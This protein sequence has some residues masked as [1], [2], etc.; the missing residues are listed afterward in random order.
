MSFR[1]THAS[2]LLLWGGLVAELIASACVHQVL[3]FPSS[4]V[5]ASTD[6]SSA[7][8]NG[9]GAAPVFSQE[10]V[11]NLVRL[12]DE[13]TPLVVRGLYIHPAAR[14]AVEQ[15]MSSEE[16]AE[17]VIQN[18]LPRIASVSYATD[19]AL[20]FTG[21]EAHTPHVDDQCFAAYSLQLKGQKLW[22]IWDWNSQDR[23]DPE[24]M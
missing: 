23:E 17:M 3:S 22:E 11:E 9:G 19:G 21:V 8:Y 13:G 20:V 5:V 16:I 14:R 1:W 2:W 6:A 4:Q 24:C 18:T 12:L 10:F 15:G 7:S